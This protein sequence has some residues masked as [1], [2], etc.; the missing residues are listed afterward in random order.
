M[1]EACATVIIGLQ[2]DSYLATKMN[3]SNSSGNLASNESTSSARRFVV[4]QDTVAGIH[5]IWFTVV[6]N[7]PVTVELGN[8]IGGTRV[9]RSSFL[10]G[11]LD[12]LTVEF[13]GGSLVE[14][15]TVLE[16]ASAD[17]I[18]KTESTQGINVTSVFRHIERDLDVGLSTQVVDF[19]R[20]NL[21]DDVDK[22][23]GVSKITVVQEELDA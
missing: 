5:V 7:D 4:E 8:T 2:F 10:L 22:A 12:D 18:Q 19:S 23:C 13:G 3:I 17:S 20:L 1:A 21:A 6:D 14:T 15:D 9:E 16:T 11:S